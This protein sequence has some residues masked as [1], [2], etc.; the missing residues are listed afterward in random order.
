M[1]RGAG[2]RYGW[3][4]GGSILMLATQ[5]HAREKRFDLAPG[6]AVQTLSAFAQQSG[7]QII[8]PADRLRGVRTPGIVGNYEVQAALA[9][10]L[11]GTPLCVARVKAASIILRE[12]PVAPVP[13]PTSARDRRRTALPQRAPPDAESVPIVVTGTRRT[14]R[15]ITD[16]ATPVTLIGREALERQGVTDMGSILRAL[17]PSFNMTRPTIS[18]GSS[19]VPPPTLRGLPPD[20]VLVL[21]N[22]KRRHRSAL[23]QLAGGP[24]AAGSQ[25]ADLAQ[26]PAMA[27]DRVEILHDGAA[28]IYG[29][30]AIAGVIDFTLREDVGRFD[31]RMRYGQYYAGDGRNYQLSG[32]YGAA[33]GA[34]FVSIAGEFNDNGVT[35]R[36]GQR[37]G[38]W[39][40]RKQ[41]PQY[42]DLVGDPVQINGNPRARA[43]KL[44]LNA[45]MPLGPGEAYLFGNAGRS[46][47]RRNSNWRQGLDVTGPDAL[48]TGTRLYASATGIYPTIWLDQLPNGHYDA[49]GRSFSF[50]SLYPAGFLPQFEA[51]ITDLSVTAGYRGALANDLRYDLSLSRGVNRLRYH[52]AN[53]LNPSLGPASPTSFYI[54][55]L[56]QRE[57][58]LNADLRYDWDMG[59]ASPVSIAFGAERRHEAYAITAGERLSWD[60]GPW[61]IAQTVEWPDGS[62]FVNPGLAIG[63]NGLPGFSPSAAIDRG[64]SSWALYADVEADPMSG[65]TL[66]GALRHEQFSDFGGTTNWKVKARYALTDW[67]ALRGAASTGFRAPT[68]GQ[69][70]TTSVSLTNVDNVLR[71]VATLPPDNPAARF[72]GATVLRP[73]RS[74]NYVAGLVLTPHPRLTASVDLYRIDLRDRIGLSGNFIVST[75]AQREALRQMGVTS[76]ARLARVRYF[77]NA[78]ATRTQGLDVSISHRTGDGPAGRLVTSLLLN[79]NRTRITARDAAV[80]DDVRAGNI[81]DIVP[82]WR[83]TLS[84][85]WTLR[86]VAVNARASYYHSFTSHAL[87]TDG[88][89]L[90]LRAEWTFDLET[91]VRLTPKVRLAMGGEN[92]FDN[93]P[94]LNQRSMGLPNQNWYGFT[95]TTIGGTRYVD[96]SPFGFNGGFWYMRLELSL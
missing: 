60:V 64:R 48:G 61:G 35:V 5:A 44:F 9:M 14:D 21:V 56:E 62:S 15:T 79:H 17:V 39:L 12:C 80:I 54:G 34:G 75:D 45:A 41:Y 4:L 27:I 49:T 68:P 36:N 84:A 87:P 3:A 23:V 81:E 86:G 52:I 6:P 96:E 92:I 74:T 65:L 10:L 1:I 31:M 63:A 90:R 57:A 55:T 83:G 71:E 29:S 50:T 42:A 88:G 19:F 51:T 69:L 95:G 13:K 30:D 66:G 67:M 25:A 7:T 76:Y 85:A 94:D 2:G 73:E 93:Y 78:F 38:A 22:G 53:T 43:G 40:I 37:P 58:N 70:Y 59:L 18:D 32:Y 82:R 20:E 28:A 89:N 77:T 72:F 11:R 8:A 33:L 24:L 16:L 47:Q 46:K 91:S 26:I